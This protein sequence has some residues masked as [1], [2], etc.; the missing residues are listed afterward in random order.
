MASTLAGL[1]V[2]IPVRATMTPNLRCTRNATAGF[3]LLRAPVSSNVT[4]KIRLV[5]APRLLVAFDER[6]FAARLDGGEERDHEQHRRHR[7]QDRG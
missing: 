3:A 5:P 4:L 2:F 1:P 7:E 6:L